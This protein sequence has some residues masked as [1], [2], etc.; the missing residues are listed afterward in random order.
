MLRIGEFSK[1]AQV[2]VKTLHYYDQY[3][4]LKPAWVDRF[5]G[6][7]YYHIQ[8]LTNLN[9]ILALKELGFSLEQIQTIM[10][11]APSG[12]ELRRMMQ[13]KQMELEKQIQQDTVRL[14]QI[15]TRLRQI[16]EESAFLRQE[17]VIKEIPNRLVVGLRK[18]V[19][20]YGQVFEL[21][22]ELCAAVPDI[23]RQPDPALPA[24]AIHY[25][26][27]YLEDQ[28]QVELVTPVSRR[29][30]LPRQLKAYQLEGAPQMACLIHQGSL[31]VLPQI[32]QGLI[33]WVEA[34]NYRITGT[35]REVF[36]QGVA[37]PNNNAEFTHSPVSEPD[38]TFITELQVPVERRP[39]PIF[40]QKI[41]EYPQM[42]PKI[43]TKPAFTVVGLK[44]YGKNENNEIPKLWAKANPRM[45][46]IKHIVTS[47]D[48]A[49]GIC[50]DMVENGNFSY[51]AG[52]A[53]SSIEDI[54]EG[55]DSWGSAGTN[56]RGLPYHTGR[57]RADL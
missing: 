49:Y 4:L 37:R 38:T 54:P 36:L 35:N 16:N 6:Y 25:D 17:V 2:S 41:K 27:E 7:R 24:A 31:E 11:D 40:I 28:M 10:Q 45:H 12:N 43:E 55:M 53:V 26:Q 32:Y 39:I 19:S 30:K 56:L 57:H 21:Y 33:G 52:L 1:I 23:C 50:G 47:P 34:N 5:N 15:E 42:E 13:L 44:Y 9:R 48:A 3:G 14:H 22:E 46:E 8:Q 51:L 20:G 18:T 29:Q